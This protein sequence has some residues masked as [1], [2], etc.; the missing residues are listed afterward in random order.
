M[1]PHHNAYLFSY[2]RQAEKLNH[3]H[4]HHSNQHEAIKQDGTL[5]YLY[6]DII[7]FITGYCFFFFTNSEIYTG[8]RFNDK[9]HEIF[10]NIK[11]G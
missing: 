8:L 11:Q 1:P 7:L 10:T 6:E 2:H 3:F 5:A 4:S 9:E